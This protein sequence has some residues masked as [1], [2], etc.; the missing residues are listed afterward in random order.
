MQP[1]EVEAI[2]ESDDPPIEPVPPASESKAELVD[3]APAAD[4]MSEAGDVDQ[5]DYM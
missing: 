1:K 3:A 5:N 2:P 4:T